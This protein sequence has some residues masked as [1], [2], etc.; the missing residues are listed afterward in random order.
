VQAI[1]TL[2]TLSATQVEVRGASLAFPD[3]GGARFVGPAFT[4]IV[5]RARDSSG[6]YMAPLG[7][8]VP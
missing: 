4:A 7:A 5:F 6:H 2:T 3:N 1:A 8:D